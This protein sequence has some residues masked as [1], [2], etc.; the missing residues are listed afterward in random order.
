MTIPQTDLVLTQSE[1]DTVLSRWLGQTVR[2]DRIERLHGGMINS[3]L[4][5]HFDIPPHDAVIKVSKKENDP[6]FLAE[7]KRLEY[8]HQYTEFPCPRLY[9]H[10]G[11]QDHIPYSFLLIETLPG[12]NLTRTRL[13]PSDRDDIERDLADVLLDLHS[14]T[15]DG[16]GEIDE[17]Q[18]RPEWREVFVPR[19]KEMRGNVA[20]KVDSS[21]LS[22]I[23][24]T[25]EAAPDVFRDQGV[26]TLVH[27][28]I[29]AANVMV[30]HENGRWRLSGIVDPSSLYADVE[31][32]LAYLLVFNTAGTTFFKAYTAKNPLRPGF[33]L[34]RLY[35]WLQTYMIHVHVFGDRH[36]HQMT[37]VVA[38]GI[39]V[40]LKKVRF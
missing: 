25:L 17:E 19:M 36:Y 23:D 35:Y 26:P 32:E 12:V 20:Q 10:D 24:E 13:T 37:E 30:A 40:A 29:W 18:G 31:F 5:L 1:A 39:K 21:L 2:C 34:R 6:G 33:E 14:H 3:V 28:D 22:A 27:G 9:L 8:L 16:Y 38:E 11:S 4:K 7:R 15:R